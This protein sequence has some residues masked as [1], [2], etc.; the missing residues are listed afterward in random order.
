MA[1][2]P[3]HVIGLKHSSHLTIIFPHENNIFLNFRENTFVVEVKFFSPFSVC[4]VLWSPF[5]AT[6]LGKENQWNEQTGA[7]TKAIVTALFLY[8]VLLLAMS[9]FRHSHFSFSQAE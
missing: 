1:N 6:K 8:K 5:M 3:Q 9:A 2:Y 7:K 4:Q